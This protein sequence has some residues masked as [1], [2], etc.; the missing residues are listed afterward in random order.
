MRRHWRLRGLGATNWQRR[1]G[2]QVHRNDRLRV[3]ISGGEHSAMDREA[4]PWTGGV[5]DTGTVQASSR[6][7]ELVRSRLGEME[8][9]TPGGGAV[10]PGYWDARARRFAAQVGT[11]EGDPL[12]SR[13]GRAGGRRATVLDVGAGT[14]RFT[15]ALAPRVGQVVAVDS[16]GAML[17]ILRREARRRGLANIRGIEGRWEDVDAPPAEVV[18]CSYVL[19]LVEDATGFLAKL[20][21]AA[22]SRAFVSMNAVSTDLFFDPFWRHF[23]GRPRRPGPTY[24]D[25]VAVLAEL[26]IQAEVEVVEVPVRSRFSSV[27]KAAAAYRESLLLPDSAEVR[28]ELRGLLRTW[29]VG[30]EG[31]LRPPLKTT[32]AAILSWKPRPRDRR[33]AR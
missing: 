6:W 24:L 18:L 13:I 7:R 27:A 4:P 2:D 31:S 23:H 22:R 15:L 17:S 10:G 25:A 3:Q 20:D 26:G 28:R 30:P 1:Q 19:P 29:L 12:V 32:A 11:A 5:P 33:A 9:I 8:A 16:S 14:G 21:A